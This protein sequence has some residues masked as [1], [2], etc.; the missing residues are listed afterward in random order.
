KKMFIKIAASKSVSEYTPSMTLSLDG[1]KISI[2]TLEPDT[3]SHKG[4]YI[5][6]GGL[7]STTLNIGESIQVT[8]GSKSVSFCLS[9]SDPRNK[10]PRQ[11]P[12]TL[13]FFIKDEKLIEPEPI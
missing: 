2:Q 1:Q 13:I 11:E 12:H 7:E 5:Y 9:L 6:S 3:F 8:F 4:F 10:K